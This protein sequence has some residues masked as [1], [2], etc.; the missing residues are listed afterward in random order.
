HRRLAAAGLADLQTIDAIIARAEDD[1]QAFA[2]A[3]N[4]GHRELTAYEK[5]LSLMALKGSDP[6]LSLR[7]LA[8]RSG[9]PF[10]TVSSLV[11]A[12]EKSTPVL[13]RCFAEG[14]APRAV[15]ELQSSF[16]SIPEDSQMELAA[17]LTEASQAQA[18]TFRQ[19]V[20][21]GI[22]PLAA[23]KSAMGFEEKIPGE[24]NQPDQ[25]AIEK[26][27]NRVRI[28]TRK[29]STSNSQKNKNLLGLPVPDDKDAL[30]A[31]STRTGASKSIVRRLVKQAQRMEADY[32]TLTLACAHAACGGEK[33]RSLEFTSRAVTNKSIVSVVRR[34]LDVRER[35]RNLI[36]T[37]E[38]PE[39]AG[40]LQT[41]FF[42]A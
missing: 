2:L 3:E 21:C 12:Y 15:Q 29:N 39:I 5:V 10:G 34:H 27:S 24:G 11:S 42:G 7:R 18:A 33:S 8:H 23:A 9:L 17:I 40:F 41:I 37:E 20:D 22:E 13:R 35:A 28:R 19:M 25:N 30:S 38:E 14:M 32:T 26:I 1:L 4:L 16:E 36:A 31:L 6:Q